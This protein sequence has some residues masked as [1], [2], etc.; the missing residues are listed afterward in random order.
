M[1]E[2]FKDIA[3]YQTDHDLLIVLNERVSTLIVAVGNKNDDHEIR[4][5]WLEKRGWLMSGA[6]LALATLIGWAISYFK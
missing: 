2:T 1:A 5:R 4:I 6:V 3:E